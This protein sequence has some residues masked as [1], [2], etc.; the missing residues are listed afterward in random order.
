MTQAELDAH[1]FQH[2]DFLVAL[3]RIMPKVIDGQAGWIVPS[4]AEWRSFN[5]VKRRAVKRMKT[6]PPAEETTTTR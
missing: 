6:C 4:T 5:T 2:I 1:W 3:G